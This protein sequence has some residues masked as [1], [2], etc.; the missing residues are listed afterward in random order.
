LFSVCLRILRS[1]W[2]LLAA[3]G[4]RELQWMAD[5]LRNALPRHGS[6]RRICGF[7]HKFNLALAPHIMVYWMVALN[8]SW[9]LIETPPVYSKFN[10]QGNYGRIGHFRGRLSKTKFHAKSTVIWAIHD[11]RDKGLQVW[12]K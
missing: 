10:F 2:L 8:M 11:W 1:S 7:F 6:R 4:S 12:K 3:L 9:P 5:G